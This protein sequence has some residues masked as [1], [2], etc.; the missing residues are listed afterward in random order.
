VIIIAKKKRVLGFY[1]YEKKIN[2]EIHFVLLSQESKKMRPHFFKNKRTANKQAKEIRK[3]GRKAK[4]RPYRK[5]YVI[6]FR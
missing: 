3:K 5:S 6:Y 2:K 1:E 4:V